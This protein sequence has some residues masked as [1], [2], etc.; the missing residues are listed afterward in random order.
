LILSKRRWPVTITAVQD[1]E[2]LGVVTT[3]SGILI[4]ID[5]G[6]L[7]LWSHDKKPLM[8]DGV[9]SNDEATARANS[10]VDLHIVGSDAERVGRLLN[11]S[12]H[13]LFVYDQ[14]WDNVDLRE[15]FAELI[16]KSQFD[17]RL[18]VMAERVPHRKRVDFAIEQG[19]GA[20]EIQF[21]GVW[22]V[23]VS[24]APSDRPIFVL[25]ERSASDRY[26]WSRVVVTCRPEMRI[27]QSEKVGVVGVDY[28]RLLIADVNALGDWQ[29]EESLDGLADYIF[30]GQDADK[31]AAALG[32]PTLESAEFGWTN[33][34][35]EIA[36]ER[37][38]AVESYRDE[39]SLRLAG[40]YRPHSHHWRVMTPTRTS[41]TESAT[42][43]VGGT[44]VC[45]FM[46][47][48]GD[49]VFEV[50]RDLAGSGDLVQIRIELESAPVAQT[51]SRP[52][53]FTN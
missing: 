4:L 40:D 18:E 34:T 41:E 29:H 37:G 31:V 5:T 19:R 24:G 52:M 20:G 51:P 22:A 11:V 17:A 53:R 50:Y 13:P 43:E 14:P 38:L 7:N 26:R 35:E 10:S 32:A 2:Q 44:N 16:R 9:L 30:W 25:A 1:I 23:A 27:V 33:T 42:T 36:Q 28:A 6:Y 49:G 15:K 46:T 47:T 8:P 12:W 21:H 39:H 48:W 45:N 3:R